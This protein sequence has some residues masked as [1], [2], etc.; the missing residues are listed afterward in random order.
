MIIYVVKP[1]D[2][3]DTIAAAHGISPASVIYNN[4]IPL[5]TR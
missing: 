1:G 2:T 3:V 5:P 4:Q